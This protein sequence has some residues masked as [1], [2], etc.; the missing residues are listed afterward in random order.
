MKE[1]LNNR[2][3]QSEPSAIRYFNDFALEQGAT[4]F[5]T[6]GEPDFPTPDPIKQALAKSLEENQTHY[7]P[8]QGLLSLRKAISQFEEM[9]SQ[10]YY[11]PDEILITAGSTE[12]I[13]T[14][15]STIL[16]PSDEVIVLNPAFSL[17]R[18]LIE[19]EGATCVTIDTSSTHF[20]VTEK[21]IEE[22]VTSKTKAII[23]TSPNNPTGT[24][25]NEDSLKAVQQCVL[26]HGFFVLC[27]DV[28]K[29]LV[30]EEAPSMSTQFEDIKE[31]IIVC[32]SFSKPYAMT[33]WRIGY[34]MA[35]E[36]FIKEA[37]K[38]HQYRLTC[39]TTFIQ[40]ATIAALAC[41]IDYM[42]ESYRERRDYM[43]DRLVKMGLE[44]ELPE[45]AFYMFPSIKKYGLSSWEFCEQF[46]LKEKVALIPGSCFE[47]DDFIR[48][49]YCV[50]LKTIEESMD[51]LENFLKALNSEAV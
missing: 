7:A 47:A 2:V 17:Y 31:Y 6:L 49:S 46:V 23:L 21:M 20:Q 27:D 5:L 15:L 42:V 38:V 4:H 22:K 18:Q 33:G 40:E 37:L 26:K 12:A 1:L 32:Q 8:S 10:T 25:L 35:D 28:Y 36:R 16:N 44:V 11:S 48:L 3:I 9:H 24:I 29:Q 45:G 50:S 14:A 39:V 41:P 43:Y 13:S 19:I 30:F 34:L 51:R